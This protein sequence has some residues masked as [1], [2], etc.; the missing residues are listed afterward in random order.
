MS[1]RHIRKLIGIATATYDHYFRSI[2]RVSLGDLRPEDA[3]SEARLLT[4]VSENAVTH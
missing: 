4:A 3:D 2:V 1:S